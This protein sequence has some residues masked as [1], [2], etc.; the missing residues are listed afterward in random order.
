MILPEFNRSA[1][2]LQQKCHVFN[3][4]CTFDAILGRDFLRQN[5]L[6]TMV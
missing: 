5:G 3:G 4:L 6:T 1:R 2:I